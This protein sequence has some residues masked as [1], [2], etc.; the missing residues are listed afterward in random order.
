VVECHRHTIRS[1]RYFDPTPEEQQELDELKEG[2]DFFGEELFNWLEA[3]SH[4]LPDA[5]QP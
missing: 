1:M 4:P 5:G 2:W 3:A